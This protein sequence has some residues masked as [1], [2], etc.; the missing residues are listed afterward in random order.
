MCRKIKPRVVLLH[1]AVFGF[2]FSLLFYSQRAFFPMLAKQPPYSAS[3]WLMPGKTGKAIDGER[4]KKSSEPIN[5]K[6][7]KKGIVFNRILYNDI[8]IGLSKII[9]FL[10]IRY[11]FMHFKSHAGLCVQYIK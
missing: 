7:L 3:Q 5:I 11:V 2:Y 6:R 8:S 4:K 10:L 1:V 9:I